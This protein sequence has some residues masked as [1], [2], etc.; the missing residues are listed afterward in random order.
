MKKTTTAFI[1]ALAALSFGVSSVAV[2]QVSPNAEMQKRDGAFVDGDETRNQRA[3]D[4]VADRPLNVGPETTA[5]PGVNAPEVADRDGAFVDGD[6]ARQTRAPN[7]VEDDIP[8]TGS[9]AAPPTLAD[10][11]SRGGAFVDGDEAHETRAPSPIK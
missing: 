3:P 7:P 9:I 11:E 10:T 6:A 8:A 5:Q 2:A 4:P 1:A